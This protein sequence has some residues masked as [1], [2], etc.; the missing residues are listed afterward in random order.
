MTQDCGSMLVF[1]IILEL[2]LVNHCQSGAKRVGFTQMIQE[3]GFSGTAD[4][5]L[6]DAMRM[7]LAKFGVGLLLIAILPKSRRTVHFK[8]WDVAKNNGKLFYIGLTTAE[9]FEDKDL[10]IMIQ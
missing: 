6:E 2:E 10:V 3:A 4:I 8:I 9:S 7:T 1:Q 5:T